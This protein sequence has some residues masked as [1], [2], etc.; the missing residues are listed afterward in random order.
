MI[1]G[2][3][4]GTVSLS[5]GSRFQCFGSGTLKVSLAYGYFKEATVVIPAYS[6][7]GETGDR[8]YKVMKKSQ[9]GRIQGFS[10]YFPLMIEE[11][12]TVP[13]SNGSRFQCFGPGTLKVSLAYGCFKEATVVIPAYSEGGETG[14]GRYK[15]MK[16]SQI[17]GIQGFSDS[18]FHDDEGSGIRIR[19][20]V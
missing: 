4:S 1:E 19:T 11:S 17:S 2:S 8:R 14:D 18:F 3:E 5:N 16:K 20:S 9:I 15:V 12:G 6:D 13:L 10:D 7:G